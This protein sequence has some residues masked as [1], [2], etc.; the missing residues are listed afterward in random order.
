MFVLPSDEENQTHAGTNRGVRDVERGK[1]DFVSAA[2]L[3]VEINEIHDG[4][5]SGQQ[6][7]GEISRDAA[8]DEAERDLAGQRVRIKMMAREKQCD[9]GDEGDERERGVVAAKQTPRRAGVAPVDELE[10]AGDD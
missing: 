6:A 2:L 1:T 9:E 4:V 3:Q 8:E 5:A 7:V 10:E